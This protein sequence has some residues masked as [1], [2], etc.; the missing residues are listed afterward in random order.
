MINPER[1]KVEKRYVQSWP[2]PSGAALPRKPKNFVPLPF[3]VPK[4]I[5]APKVYL[6]EGEP[7][8]RAVQA[9]GL[10][11]TTTSG[12]SDHWLDGYKNFF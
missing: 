11:A 5:P 8:G 12:C 4:L 6:V 7:C 3:A 9:I 10:C 1:G 2:G